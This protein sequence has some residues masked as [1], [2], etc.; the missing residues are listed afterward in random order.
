M[1]DFRG[2]HFFLSHSKLNFW[3]RSIFMAKKIAKK[4]K[5]TEK[6]RD[7]FQA[8]KKISSGNTLK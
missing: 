5:Y 1:E 6:I 2:E 8:K 7:L 3:L 4:C